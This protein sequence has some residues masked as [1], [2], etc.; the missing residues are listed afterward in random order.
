VREPAAA[1][2][3]ARRPSPRAPGAAWRW[4][5]AGVLEEFPQLRER[6]GYLGGNLGGGE[7]RMLAIGRAPMANPDPI[8][9]D[10]PSEGLSPRLLRQ[11]VIRQLRAHGHAALVVEQHLPLALADRIY[12]IASGRLV[13]EG[14]P[15]DLAADEAVLDAH[16]GAATARID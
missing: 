16:L 6:I 8:L 12:V 7:Q 15:V 4:D 14:T 5:L 11:V 3:P 9:M 13:F 1:D 10:A 2:Q